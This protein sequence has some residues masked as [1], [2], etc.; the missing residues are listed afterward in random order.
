MFNKNKNIIKQIA[1]ERIEILFDEAQKKYHKNPDLAKKY[2]KNMI[3]ISSH[4]K[5]KIP[6]SIKNNICRK[7]NNLL[8]PGYN[9]S[10]RIVSS[11]EYIAKK[12]LSCGNELHIFYKNK[13]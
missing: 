8:I 6:K 2:I 9:T 1:E 11:K 5:V 3:K 13:I 7:C 4:Y 10:I 12:C